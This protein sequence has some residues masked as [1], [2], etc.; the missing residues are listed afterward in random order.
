VKRWHLPIALLLMALGATRARA[1]GDA[2]IIHQKPVKVSHLA[3]T[4]VDPKGFT[5]EYAQI[6]LLDAK[7]HHSIVSTFADA[8]GKFYFADRKHGEQLELRASK[9]G[10]QIV[11]Y[12]VNI[13]T[14][15]KPHIRMVLPPAT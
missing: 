9:K 12:T 14:F 7:D 4:V 6:E 8:N 11:R 13:G 15:G 3:G 2:E 5:I 1:Q 10:F